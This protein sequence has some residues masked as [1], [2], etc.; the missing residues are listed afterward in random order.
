MPKARTDRPQSGHFVLLQNPRGSSH[1]VRR[2]KKSVD[3]A[4]GITYYLLM[5]DF[6]TSA[7]DTAYGSYGEFVDTP[8]W[9]ADEWADYDAQ[10]AEDMASYDA[11]I[12]AE[13]E[14]EAIMAQ[15][16]EPDFF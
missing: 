9:T 12:A 8:E 6:Y 7:D 5:S 10:V 14:A 3:T 1:I 16:D 11:A 15:Y 13:W 4:G 2:W